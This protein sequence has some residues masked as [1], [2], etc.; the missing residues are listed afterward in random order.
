MSCGLCCD[1]SVFPRV[2]ITEAEAETM[3]PLAEIGEKNGRPMML[4]PCRQLGADGT[5]QCYDVRPQTCRGFQCALL[6]DVA[7]GRTKPE[8]ALEAVGDIKLVRARAIDLALQAMGGKSGLTRDAPV[9]DVFK[10][11]D[12]ADG[13][14]SRD[15]DYFVMEQAMAF[16]NFYRKLL[17]KHIKRN[18]EL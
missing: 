10:A 16:H 5:C 7:G 4:Q 18:L 11:L 12:E 15:L 6:R 17:R 13:A 3:R 8:A 2:L 14:K 1:G 9:G